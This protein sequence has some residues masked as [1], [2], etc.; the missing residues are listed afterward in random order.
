M[1][2]ITDRELVAVCQFKKMQKFHGNWIGFIY[3]MR[4]RK[5]MQKRL[6]RERVNA[7]KSINP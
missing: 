3:F 4:N 7:Q 6:G 2:I 1:A 5:R